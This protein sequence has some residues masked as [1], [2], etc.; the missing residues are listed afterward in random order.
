MQCDN[1]LNVVA[2]KQVDVHSSL[3]NG[4]VIAERMRRMRSNYALQCSKATE[5]HKEEREGE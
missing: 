4:V 1:V 5:L 2:S 3:I